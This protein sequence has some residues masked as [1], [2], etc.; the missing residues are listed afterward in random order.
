MKVFGF[1]YAECSYL[2]DMGECTQSRAVIGGCCDASPG[3]DGVAVAGQWLRGGGGVHVASV[4]PSGRRGLG[5]VMLLHGRHGSPGAGALG[6]PCCSPFLLIGTGKA[7]TEALGENPRRL[8]PVR[9]LA[10]RRRGLLF[11]VDGANSANGVRS[12]VVGGCSQS[13]QDG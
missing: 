4:G 11:A 1:S 5:G 3:V 12:F 10:A 2:V 7:H 13:Q 6:A 9:S 8:G